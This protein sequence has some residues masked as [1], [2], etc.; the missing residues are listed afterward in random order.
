MV[1]NAGLEG[2][3]DLLTASGAGRLP[4]S[5]AEFAPEGAHRD[6]SCT[7]TGA[8]FARKGWEWDFLPP[9][10]I[11]YIEWCDPVQCH[12]FSCEDYEVD[13]FWFKVARECREASTA[14]RSKL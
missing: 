13:V 9:E 12:E 7:E 5:G 8:V 14:P 3:K 10:A 11:A 1:P 4:A 2:A 6:G